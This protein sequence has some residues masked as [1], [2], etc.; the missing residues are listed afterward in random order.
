MSKKEKKSVSPRRKKQNGFVIT[1]LVVMVSIVTFANVRGLVGS[2]YDSFVLVGDES[3]EAVSYLEGL[4][5]EGLSETETAELAS[6]RDDWDSWR[7]GRLRDEVTVTAED[8]TVLHGYFYNENSSVTAIAVPR[9]GMDGTAD[10]LLGPWLNE[11]TGCNIL[12]IDPR[13]HG[14]SGGN[15]FS[16]GYLENR[17]LTVWMDW[18]DENHGKQTFLLWGDASGANTV[19]FA[20][21]SGGLEGRAALV[22]AE[23][24]FASLRDM[25]D[26]TLKN[27]YKL[28]GFPFRNLIEGK[29]NRA[30]LGFVSAD[31]ELGEALA[32]AEYSVPV[33]CLISGQDTYVPC[34]MSE[35]LSGVVTETVKGGA[36]HGSVYAACR[37]E[38]ESLLKAWLTH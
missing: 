28:P 13:A 37:V 21:A 30:E 14:E 3:A 5:D 33:L 35:A 31:L 6:L 8:G 12:I 25:A 17:D 32:S 4:T 11:Q 20:A 1:M 9:F 24:P 2:Y 36:S 34:E 16:Y 7:A 22:V 10:F 26:Y 18:A 19:L 15:C 23:S 29:L 38:V 27:S